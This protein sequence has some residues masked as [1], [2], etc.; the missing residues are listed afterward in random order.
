MVDSS[1]PDGIRPFGPSDLKHVQF[2]IGASV[3]EQLPTVNSIGA[4]L[5]AEASSFVRFQTDTTVLPSIVFKRLRIVLCSLQ[6]SGCSP[7]LGRGVG[8]L[9][10]SR[11]MAPDAGLAVHVHLARHRQSPSFGSFT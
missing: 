10:P 8:R 9:H 11:R 5:P 6:A 1:A 3:M 7:R 4:S 2:L